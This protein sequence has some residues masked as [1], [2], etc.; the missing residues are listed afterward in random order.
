M[1]SVSMTRRVIGTLAFLSAVGWVSQVHAQFGAGSTWVRTDE[2]GKGITLTVEACCNGGLRL[3]YRLPPMGGQPAT[4]LTVDSPMD[5][6][7]VPTLVAG[8]PSGGTMAVKRVDDHHY[9]AVVKMGGK[10]F[11]TS[12][13]TV[14]ADGKAMTVESITQ[15]PGGTAEKIIETWVRK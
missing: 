1:R 5:G 8:K 10:P 13:G 9:K 6:T 3:I 11:G 4:M 14:S 7:E 2:Q 12:N 15:T